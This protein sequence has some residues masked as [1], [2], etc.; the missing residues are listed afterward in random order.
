[1]AGNCHGCAGLYPSVDQCAR[2]MEE[3]ECMYSITP[4]MVMNAVHYIDNLEDW[5]LAE[6]K[7]RKIFAL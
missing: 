2:H 1:M 3:P 7:Y 4:E 5:K 6:M